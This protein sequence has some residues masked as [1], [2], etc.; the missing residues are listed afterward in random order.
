VSIAIRAEIAGDAEAIR[1]V[2]AAS[3]PTAAEADL[4]DALR[5]S[6]DLRVSLVALDGDDVV[7]H[8]AFS[9]VSRATTRGGD[10]TSENIGKVGRDGI[11][12]RTSDGDGIGLAPVAVLESHRCRG[13]AAALIERGLEQ[14]REL[15]YRFAVVLGEPTY[16]RRFGFEPAYPHGL[17]DEYGG[18]DAFQVL[19][20]V[21]AGIGKDP[22]LIRYAPAFASLS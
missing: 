4:V 2:V 17:T 14:C 18:G 3:F 9:P 8:V 10:E 21:P 5:K 13:I 22:G 15:G 6:G 16:Y 19:E 20:F 12:D 7:G 11:G 1:R